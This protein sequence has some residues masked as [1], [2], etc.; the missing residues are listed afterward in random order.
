MDRKPRDP[1]RR[2]LMCKAK[3]LEPHPKKNGEITED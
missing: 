3:A 1:K 2:G